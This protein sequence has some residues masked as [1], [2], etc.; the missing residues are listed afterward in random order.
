MCNLSCVIITYWQTL[1]P[2]MDKMAQHFINC[3]LKSINLVTS[4]A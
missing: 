3:T 4:M 1:S 2:H